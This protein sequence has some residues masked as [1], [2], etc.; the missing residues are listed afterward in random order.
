MTLII[1][2]VAI[3]FLIAG[4]AFLIT[5]YR[6]SPA[7]DTVVS[8]GA[9][10]VIKG[11][12]SA[13]QEREK[14][15]K[16][17]LDSLAVAVDE[18]KGKGEELQ[19]FEREVQSIKSQEEGYRTK[20]VQ[21]EGNLSFI[22]EKADTQAKE[23]IEAINTLTLE[24]ARLKTDLEL[25]AAMARQES[26][27]Q[28]AKAQEIVDRIQQENDTLKSGVQG[29]MVKINEIE[30]E[31]LNKKHGQNSPISQA[32]LAENELRLAESI[33]QIGQLHDRLES[34]NDQ[35]V[36]NDEKIKS[37]E[38]SLAVSQ[39]EV[40]QAQARLD[41]LKRDAAAQ[42]QR[43][44]LESGAEMEMHHLWAEEKEEFQSNLNR[45]QEMNEYLIEKE[46][47]LQLE[48]TKARTQSLGWQKIYQE[49]KAQVEKKQSE[50]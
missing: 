44:P 14:K 15:L 1:A 8:T 7:A 35:I 32:A 49:F 37:L 36:A 18:A 50:A 42:P 23:S 17:Q 33:A 43:L 22:R 20:I 45:L 13:A 41:E 25:N 38:E 39:Q 34:L 3:I 4:F 24:N 16:L 6:E 28:I 5:G 29:M 48:L 2:L 10:D 31:F 40:Q 47:K 19:K 26:A 11:E 27:E 21:L 46:K 30:K 12:L 9:L